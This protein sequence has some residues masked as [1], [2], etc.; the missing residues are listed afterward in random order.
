MDGDLQHPP[1]LVPALLAK[2]ES[3]RADIAIASRLARGGSVG[4]LGPLRRFASR[5][6]AILTR[7]LFVDRLAAVTDP[8]TGFFVVRRAAIDTARLRP[9]GFK[10]LLEILVR[11]PDLAVVELPFRFE[12]RGAERSKAGAREVVRLGRLLA[13]LSIARE[14]H[15]ARFL[16]VGAVGFLINNAV[17]AALTELLGIYYLVSA[18]GATAVTTVWNFTLAELW[19]FGDR[20]RHDRLGRRLGAYL[21]MSAAALVAR[22]PLL[23]LL[24]S[25]LGVHYLV[26]NVLSIGVL[27]GARYAFAAHWIWRPSPRDAGRRSKG[28]APS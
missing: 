3:S 9:D 21:A 16:A 17:M 18:V 12:R 6:F 19:I 4:P 14:R 27:T 1:E 20:K 15:L 25:V 22:S 24:T 7:G 11:T 8:M 26:S 2:A 5:F 13:R 28:G 10:I 23:F